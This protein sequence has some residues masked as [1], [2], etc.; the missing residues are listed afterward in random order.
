MTPP[1]IAL[2]L[3]FALDLPE[4]EA[5]GTTTVLLATLKE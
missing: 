3:D 2:V 5:G 4:P 1:A